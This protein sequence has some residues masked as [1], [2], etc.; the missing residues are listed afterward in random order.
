MKMMCQEFDLSIGAGANGLSGQA[1]FFLARG[2]QGGCLMFEL[3]N[4]GGDFM[5]IILGV[6]ILGATIVAERAYAYWIRF[7]LDGSALFLQAI[8]N[9]RE[10]K[11]SSAIEVCNV[12]K[13]KPLADV[14]KAGLLKANAPDKDLQRTLE[15]AAGK[16]VPKITARMSFL[17]MLGNVAT[18]LGLL[19]TI[20][21]LI[22]SF[23][24]VAQADAA[25][26]QEI[27]SKGIAVAMFTT[28]FG[29]VAAIFIIVCHSVL[30]NRQTAILTQIE[31]H[32]S[33][34]FNFLSEKNRKGMPKK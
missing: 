32:A 25:A 18:L 23:R 5:W 10:G 17:P 8:D 3:M 30:H 31:D 6:S 29:L 20:L 27:L 11:L 9:V 4:R 15:S 26:K 34:L 13:G 16:A 28:A 1:V 12:Q 22:D 24:G 7:R 33:D 21:G 19:G 2:D 14:L